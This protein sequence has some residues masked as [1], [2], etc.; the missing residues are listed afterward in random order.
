MS[1]LP[2]NYFIFSMQGCPLTAFS[3]CPK[4]QN[5]A[6]FAGP[7]S[8]SQCI[9][10]VSYIKFGQVNFEIHLPCQ[11]FYLPRA[12]IE[13]FRTRGHVGLD[14]SAVGLQ[15]LRNLAALALAASSFSSITNSFTSSSSSFIN[16]ST[17]S[18]N[19]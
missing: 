18:N 10:S 4:S 5:E 17:I 2:I 7:F 11:F 9:S 14:N 13:Q 15:S 6:K 3:T 1:H 12:S 16:S 8:K 19:N